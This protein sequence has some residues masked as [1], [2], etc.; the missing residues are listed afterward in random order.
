MQNGE[1]FRGV[2]LIETWMRG[3]VNHILDKGR[4]ERK[5]GE[6]TLHPIVDRNGNCTKAVA[7]GLHITFLRSFFYTFRE[8]M[9]QG[10]RHGHMTIRLESPFL[11]GELERDP[12]LRV[13]SRS[14]AILQ[15]VDSEYVTRFGRARPPALAQ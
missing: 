4:F 7:C 8:F 5:M 3:A 14:R 15:M 12:A 13:V 2:E 11:E 9:W 10:D 6:Y 1:A